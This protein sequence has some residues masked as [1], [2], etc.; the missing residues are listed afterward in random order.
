MA[1]QNPFPV[2]VIFDGRAF[3]AE[4]SRAVQ[5]TH[6]PGGDMPPTFGERIR[7]LLSAELSPLS[8]VSGVLSE[9]V[10]ASQRSKPCRAGRKRISREKPSM[11]KKSLARLVG[12]CVLLFAGITLAQV[13]SGTI[14]AEKQDSEANR[15]GPPC[16]ATDQSVPSGLVVDITPQ[17]K[18][19]PRAVNN[20][21]I[22]GV[23]FQIHWSDIEPGEGKLDWSKLDELFA[24]AEASKR[25]V[26]L[27]I[28]PG[29]FAPA[30]ALEGVKIAQFAIQYGP[31]RGT[32]LPLPMPWDTVY[33][34]RWFAFL[35]ELSA[36]YGKSPAFKMIGAAGP[37]SVSVEMTLPSKPEDIGVWR[38]D[39]YTPLKFTAAWQKTFQM[40]AGEFPNQYVSLSVGSGLNINDRGK[41]APREGAHTRDEVI[42]Q[43]IHLLGRRFVLQNSDLHAGPNQHPVTGVV[44]SYSGRVITGL[45][46]RCGAER[47][48]CSLALGA[49]GDPPLALR[50]SIDQGMAPNNAGRHVNFLEI[51]QSDVL[52]DETQAVLRYG[53]SLFAQKQ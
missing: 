4:A 18:L 26:H 3:A 1:E 14:S 20:P 52:A 27:E 13:R 7:R 45:E 5:W 51:H 16:T 39:G 48:T 44:M 15:A 49:G 42:D 9:P 12:V 17:Q 33:L 37:T 34:N 2:P 25:W 38:N 23:A 22:S 28:F 19:D 43:A 31:G 24:A 53:A 29:F 10:R 35:K 41:I 50:K 6:L 11:R 36:R 47:G 32:V 21:C 8:A 46:M 30:W 40:Y